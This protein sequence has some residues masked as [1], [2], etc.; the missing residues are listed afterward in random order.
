ML[1]LHSRSFLKGYD[2]KAGHL[3][4]ILLNYGLGS[5][6]THKMGAYFIFTQPYF[7]EELSL[8]VFWF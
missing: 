8:S 5:C 7:S 2:Y 6:T 4:Y 3:T 1:Q